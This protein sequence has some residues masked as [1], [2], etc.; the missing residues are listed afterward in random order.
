MGWV[1]LLGRSFLHELHAYPQLQNNTNT[2]CQQTL[3]NAY[4]KV[5]LKNISLPAYFFNDEPQ[6]TIPFETF[7][8]SLCCTG[9]ECADRP[10]AS[11]MLNK[12]F[13]Q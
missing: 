6:G 4:E 2:T 1:K 3:L 7:P 12:G 8:W 11:E 5:Y 9:V 13:P 10:V